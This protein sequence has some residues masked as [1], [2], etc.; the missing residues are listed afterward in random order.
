MRTISS[1]SGR[2]VT[3]D[4]KDYLNFSTTNYL[5]LSH[6]S[7]YKKYFLEGIERY[8][9]SYGSSPLSNP[10]LDIYSQLEEYLADYYGAESALLFSNGYAASQTT[11][12]AYVDQGFDIVYGK[13][14]H[15]AL[16]VSSKNSEMSIF[17]CDIVNPINCD[18]LQEDE[19]PSILPCVIDASH[20]FGIL[21]ER[22]KKYI[23]DD[24]I[25]CGSLNKGLATQAGIILCS[26]DFK[27]QLQ[28]HPLYSTSS[29][30]S[31]AAC[32]AL[33]MS[34]NSGVVG[35]QQDKL[36][37]L[38]EHFSQRI[39][40]SSGLSFPVYIPQDE[41]E[42]LYNRCIDQ[43]VLIWRNRYP[44]PDS[45]EINRAVIHAGLEMDDI[46]KLLQL[47]S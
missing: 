34:Y 23:A 17:A 20:G 21:D 7:E 14:T 1:H 47:C 16:N 31:P 5:N 4:G 8:G 35:N 2:H 26:N 19:L 33:I 27:K 22:I 44:R 37:Q 32:Y 15:P 29:P 38:I 41:S 40:E 42:S 28:A 46:E 13:H 25:I 11:M 39:N 43:Q 6:T 30:P 45:P 18:F 10:R 3:I 9:T 36:N 24:H 12:Q